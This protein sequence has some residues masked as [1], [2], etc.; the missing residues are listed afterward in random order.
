MIGNKYLRDLFNYPD[1]DTSLNQLL[2]LLKC[3]DAEFIDSLKR[4][5]VDI[6]SCTD[7]EIKFL[8]KAS[9]L[10]DY[11]L[12]LHNIEVPGWLRNEKLSFK[13]PYYHSRRISDFDKVRLQYTNPAPFRARN[14]Y[15]D[16]EGIKRV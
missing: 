2:E 12:Q 16:L 4:E 10:I 8:A 15:F 3:K 5:P 13:K 14:V 9:A 6:N 11:Y 7:L 1:E